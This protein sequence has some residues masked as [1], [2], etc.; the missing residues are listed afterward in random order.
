VVFVKSLT[1]FSNL[2]FFCVDIA[3]SQCLDVER[4]NMEGIAGTPKPPYYAVIF[5]HKK[6][7]G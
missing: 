6:T 5:I 1:S 7:G 4:K 3:G 2:R